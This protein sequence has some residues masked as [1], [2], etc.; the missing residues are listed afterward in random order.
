MKRYFAILIAL[1]AMATGTKVMA[2][3]KE[4]YAV[5]T[6]GDNGTLTFYYDTQRSTQQG[7]VYSLNTS[8][9]T[10]NNTSNYPLWYKD[11]KKFEKVVFTQS[12]SEYKPTITS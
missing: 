4:A 5:Y 1:V 9:F 10:N 11:N 7:D 2:A 12:F 8:V 6:S 3:E